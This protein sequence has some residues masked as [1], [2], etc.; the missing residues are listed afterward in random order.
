MK[1][2]QLHVRITAC[3]YKF[4]TGMAETSEETIATVVRRLIRAAIRAR[5]R[6]SAT[7]NTESVPLSLTQRSHGNTSQGNGSGRITR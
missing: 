4:L 6:I 7:P 5:E 3:E 2:H 1:R